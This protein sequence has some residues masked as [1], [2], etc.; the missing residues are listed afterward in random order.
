MTDSEKDREKA[1]A[2]ILVKSIG[3]ALA[4]ILGIVSTNGLVAWDP[5]RARFIVNGNYVSIETIRRE[6][7]R[8]ETATGIRMKRLADALE[9]GE[10]DLDTWTARMKELVGS[11]HVIMASLAAGSIAA[12]VINKTVQ[13]AIVDQRKFVNS[14][15]KDV[16]IKRLP[17][18]TIAARAKSYL[19]VAGVTYALVEHA[20]RKAAGYTEAMRVRTAE[21]SCEGCIRWSGKWYPIGA[22][23]I[24]GSLEC[25]NYCR[26]YL[27][28]R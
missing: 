24:I 27:V 21:E 7:L 5:G 4:I 17:S 20:V 12:A 10:I 26:C 8:F 22:I 14:F 28:Y 13:T 6:L 3:G 11:S 1:R 15:A 25:L 2:A 19:L 23:A 18:R 16:Q 9:A